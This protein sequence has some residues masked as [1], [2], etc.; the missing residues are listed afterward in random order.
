[1][2]EGWTPVRGY[3]LHYEVSNQGRVRRVRG[4]RGATA[5]RILRAKKPT[6]FSDY[7][8][9]QLCK[10]DVKRTHAVHILVCEAFHGK[11]PRGKVVN[12]KN[13]G[14]T[15]NRASN[16]EWVTLKQNA[17]HAVR[18]GRRSTVGLTG[19][20][21]GRAKLTAAQV[22]EIRRLKGVVGQRSLALLCGVSK[23]AI[24]TIHQGKHWR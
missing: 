20:R 19:E 21:N 2:T 5:G 7:R 12:H 11:R 14:K 6:R 18:N 10:N 23:T 1:M 9:V 3:E 13:M 16:L 24:Q 22:A 15:D 4:G 8:R 17:R